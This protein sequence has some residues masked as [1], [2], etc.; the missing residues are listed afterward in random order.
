MADKV[1]QKSKS[2]VKRENAQ[3]PV[4]DA[5]AYVRNK[6]AILNSGDSLNRIKNASRVVEQ[7]RAARKGGKK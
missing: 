5:K 2:T 3:N 6:L 7:E 1:N 4:V